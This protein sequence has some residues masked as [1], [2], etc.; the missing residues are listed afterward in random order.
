MRPWMVC[1]FIALGLTGCAQAWADSM[2]RTIARD[3][4]SIKSYEGVTVERHISPDGDVRRRV[5]YAKPWRFRVET[6]APSEHAGELFV[7]DG[8]EVKMWWPKYRFGVRVRGLPVVNRAQIV[9]H[10]ERLARESMDAYAF[11]L[12]SVAD[13]VAG[14]RTYAWRLIPTR[15]APHRYR[16]VVWNDQRYAMP[17]KLAID[18]HNGAPWY[19]MEFESIAFD[20]PVAADAFAF[21]FPANAVVFDWDL[22][23]PGITLDEAREA[24]NF[25]V[26]VPRQ[27]IQKIVRAVHCLPMIT[28]VMGSGASYVSLTESRDMGLVERPLGKA[29]RIGNNPAVLTLLG[30]FATIT[31]V[32]GGTLL[33]LTGNI[34]FPELI[35]VAESVH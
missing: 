25:D 11:S 13:R 2:A 32:Q 31:W 21:E 16:H 26:K 15:E 5:V 18:D 4:E 33:S 7:Y 19:S 6:L 9:Q 3:L 20:R 22:S 8:S 17:L 34:G 29:I 14:Q 23:A 10:I 28:L 24:M 27:P 30:P 1:L 35:A 12:R